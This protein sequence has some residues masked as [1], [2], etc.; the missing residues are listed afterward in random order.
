MRFLLNIGKGIGK[1]FF[2]DG[3]AWHVECVMAL[4]K[5]FDLLIRDDA[6]LFDMRNEVAIKLRVAVLH[7]VERF[8]VEGPTKRL[9]ALPVEVQ[10]I[11][12]AFAVQGLRPIKI[13]DVQLEFLFGKGC[14]VT[15]LL[16]EF[17]F[18]DEAAFFNLM[19]KRLMV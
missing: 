7:G 1:K 3:T 6:F 16:R 9:L 5:R 8:M 18:R 4:P 2:F 17:S 19:P 15:L 13:A 11:L 12:L 14:K 10:G